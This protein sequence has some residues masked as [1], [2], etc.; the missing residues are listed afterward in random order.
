MTHEWVRQL[1]EF[2]GVVGIPRAGMLEATIIALE[3]GKPLTVP[4]LLPVNK[5]YGVA[6]GPL[7]EDESEAIHRILIVDDSVTGGLKM[8]QVEDKIRE[9]RPDLEIVKGALHA[10]PSATKLIDTCYGFFEHRYSQITF[11]RDMIDWVYAAAAL[12]LDGILCEEYD[13]K[14]IVSEEQ[15][16]AWITN[17]KPYRIPKWEIPMILTGRKE[18]F[19]RQ[20]ED[21]LRRHN[22]KFRKLVM[23]PD[24]ESQ[25]KFKVRALSREKPYW[26]WESSPQLAG[27]IQSRLGIKVL[28]FAN[29][30]VYG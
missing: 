9:Q 13:G 24:D 3:L 23:C 28:C 19:R 5:W 12:D 27:Y 1:P 20:T 22:A 16:V 21:W 6:N 4:D 29:M 11:E 17:A 14:N 30:R 15:Y 2:D 26:Y 10:Q 7:R 8:K 18:K 25:E